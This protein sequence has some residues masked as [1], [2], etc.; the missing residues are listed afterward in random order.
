MLTLTRKKRLAAFVDAQLSVRC[1]SSEHG[2]EILRP[3][4]RADGPSARSKAVDERVETPNNPI[5]PLMLREIIGRV[6]RVLLSF[7]QK[8]S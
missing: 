4:G 5:P 1:A 2:A 7:R 3:S 8:L 6:E